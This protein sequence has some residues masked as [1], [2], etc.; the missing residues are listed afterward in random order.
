MAVSELGNEPFS[1]T[2]GRQLLVKDSAPWG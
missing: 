1:F 2:K